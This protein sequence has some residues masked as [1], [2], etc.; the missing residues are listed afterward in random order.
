MDK[1]IESAAKLP[2]ARIEES[3]PPS[4]LQKLK[5]IGRCLSVSWVGIYAGL[6]VPLQYVMDYSLVE[7]D[8]SLWTDPLIVW[9]LIHAPSGTRKSRIHSFV[10]S[11]LKFEE[12]FET[13]N[14]ENQALP[15]YK[16]QETTFENLGLVMQNNRGRVIWFFDEARH[17]FAQLGYY[18]KG[19]STRDENLL[20][21]LY[22]GGEWDHGTSGS[23]S[24]KF[25]I[26]KTHLVLGGCTQT[27]HIVSLFQNQEQ[28]QS[29]LI[30]RFLILMLEPVRTPIER[31]WERQSKRI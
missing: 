27:A 11:L 31:T 16:V 1:R 25:K 9:P 13:E 21:S 19:G 7:L 26:P 23:K 3:I 12:Y 17:F 5:E 14:E 22:D 4:L 24:T 20:L 6:F 8:Q 28:M 18:N 30:P 10:N 2:T 15:Q 29:G